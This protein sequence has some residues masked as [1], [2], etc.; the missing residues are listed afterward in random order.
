[1][2]LVRVRR[3]EILYSS[4]LAYKI[5]QTDS[6]LDSEV[7]GIAEKSKGKGLETKV[8]QNHRC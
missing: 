6:T 2:L 3:K 4:G 7:D 5:S 1:M 8:S